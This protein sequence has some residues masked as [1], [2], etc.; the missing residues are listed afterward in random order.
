MSVT[1]EQWDGFAAAFGVLG[2]LHR[3]APD[4]AELAAFRGL[5]PQWPL[6]ETPRAR[7]G[8]A[9]LDRSAALGE[10][11]R[12][13]ADDHNRLY[14][15]TARALVA[16][17]ESVHRGVEGLVF[18]DATMDV[19]AAYRQLGLQAPKLNREPDDHIGLEFDFVAQLCL[20]ALDA[21]DEDRA[22]DAERLLD[23]LRRFLHDHLQQWAPGMLG[24]VATLAGTR[25]MAGLALLSQGAL[26][27]LA[28][29]L[30]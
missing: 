11:A 13:I 21:L 16:P 17:Y 26:S 27:S 20:Q 23:T 6:A 15:D 29:A 5:Q 9:A 10:T 4:E 14:G 8:M 19:R 1:A 18:D 25:F 7:E 22:D 28:T 3:E 24:Q 2:K 12:Q 30:E